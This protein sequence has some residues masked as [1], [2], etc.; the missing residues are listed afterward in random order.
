MLN[1][2]LDVVSIIGIGNRIM[3]GISA[4][5]LQ[6]I[7]ISNPCAFDAVLVHFVSV[8]ISGSQALTH[9][10]FRSIETY[11]TCEFEYSL[12][13]HMHLSEKFQPTDSINKRI[14]I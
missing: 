3:T 2:E 1:K 8:P 6:W 7:M 13:F 14:R 11:F 10:F 4:N 12:I 9:A 5:F